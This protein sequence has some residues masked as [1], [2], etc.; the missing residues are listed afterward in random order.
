MLRGS[1]KS[2]GYS[3]HLPVSPSLPFP[4]VTVCHHFSTGVYV[5]SGHGNLKLGTCLGGEVKEELDNVTPERIGN[6]ERVG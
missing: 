5:D 6:I 3:L 1:V 4:C 2:N